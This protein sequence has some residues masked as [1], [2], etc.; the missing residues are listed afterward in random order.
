MRMRNVTVAVAVALGAFFVWSRVMQRSS[1]PGAGRQAAPALPNVQAEVAGTGGVNRDSMRAVRRAVR[2][3]IAESDGY[4]SVALAETDSVLRRWPE[5]RDNPIR[6]YLPEQGAP[7]YETSFGLAVRRALVQWTSVG[8]VPVR[9]SFV[10]EPDAAEIEIRWVERFNE[11]R[12]GVAR[13]RWTSDG[14]LIGGTLTLATHTPQGQPLSD[15]AICTR[16]A[17]CWGWDTPTTLMT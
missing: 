9:F 12:T 5:R 11:N 1:A 3:R 16:L 7:G 15:D 2:R 13:V 4:L 8:G 14:W 6:V 10:R 17:T